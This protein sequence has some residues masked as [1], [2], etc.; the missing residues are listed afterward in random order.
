MLPRR[1]CPAEI[2]MSTSPALANCSSTQTGLRHHL[3]ECRGSTMNERQSFIAVTP[4]AECQRW[5]ATALADAGEIIPADTASIERI[6]QLSD[7]VGA[8][9]VFMHLSAA[10]SEE[11]RVGKE[12]VSTCRAG[13]W[14]CH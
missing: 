14:P 7:A 6:L 8:A 11:R 3:P 12:C 5:L 9:A 10:G 1:P 13:W 2:C 4:D